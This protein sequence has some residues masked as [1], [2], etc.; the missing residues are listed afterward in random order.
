M[1]F[2][3]E[4][5]TIMA[6]P[7]IQSAKKALR[8]SKKRRILNTDKKEAL[9]S[10]FNVLKKHKKPADLANVYRLADKAV[11]ARVIHKNKAGR[12]KSRAA[13]IISLSKSQEKLVLE[14]YDKVNRKYMKLISKMKK[15]QKKISRAR[16]SRLLKNK[17]E[18]Q[19]YRNKKILIVSDKR[20]SNF[21]SVIFDVARRMNKKTVMTV[22]DNRKKLGEEPEQAVREAME[23][24]DVILVSAKYYLEKTKTLK[25]CRRQGKPVFAVKKSL[26]ATKMK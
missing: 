10:A 3:G 24:A 20:N 11:K 25:R 8:Q 14:L 23:K 9:K 4:V 7:I 5:G 19:K 18:L 16:V 1:H 13:D 12:I 22:M 17:L 6:M 2:N 15:G 26:H 21:A